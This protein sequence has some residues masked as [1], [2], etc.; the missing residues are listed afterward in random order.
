MNQFLLDTNICVHLLKNE[1]GIKEKIA[2]VGTKSCFLSEITIAELL[3]GIENSAP[4]KRKENIE[5]FENLRSLFLGRTLPISNV[6]YEYARQ[7]ASV[8]RIGRPVGEFDLLIGATSIVHGLTL[9]TRN[10]KDFQNLE[11]IQLENWID[12]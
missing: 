4:T 5:C 8:R 2:A 6:L 11:R 10:T 7:K 9:V 3:Y 12:A 1:Y